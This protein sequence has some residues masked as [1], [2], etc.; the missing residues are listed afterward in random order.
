M[1]TGYLIFLGIIFI[2]NLVINYQIREIL[3]KEDCESNS[4]ITAIQEIVNLDLYYKFCK[5]RNISLKLYNF[6]VAVKIILAIGLVCIP[7]FI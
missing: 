5:D 3:I 6:S 1:L 7:L 4:H 2:T